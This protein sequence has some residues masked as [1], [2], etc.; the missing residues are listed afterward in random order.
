MG[1]LGINSQAAQKPNLRKALEDALHKVMIELL[2]ERKA[3]R[4]QR[5]PETLG[6]FDF[7]DSQYAWE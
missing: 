6:E 5:H 1:S 2:E 3:E 4:Y 7:L